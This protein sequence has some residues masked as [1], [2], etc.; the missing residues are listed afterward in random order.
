MSWR[1][2]RLE[3][4]N[5]IVSGVIQVKQEDRVDGLLAVCATL[6]SAF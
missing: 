4:R 6:F 5:F 3:A 1:E 2:E